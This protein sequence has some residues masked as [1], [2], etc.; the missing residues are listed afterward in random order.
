MFLRYADGRTNGIEMNED[1]IGF[2]RQTAII[3]AGV[4]IPKWLL[5]KMPNRN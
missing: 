3:E 2:D 5:S 4:E 1:Q